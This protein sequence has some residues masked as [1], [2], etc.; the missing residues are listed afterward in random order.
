MSALPVT[1]AA[2]TSLFYTRKRSDVV[3][4]DWTG[5]EVD[6]TRFIGLCKAI[7]RTGAESVQFLKDGTVYLESRK[8]GDYAFISDGAIT[9]EAASVPSRELLATYHLLGLR[10][11]NPRTVRGQSI[12]LTFNTV[13]VLPAE[14]NYRRR[15][16]VFPL[17]D[18]LGERLSRL[19]EFSPVPNIWLTP[20]PWTGVIRTGVPSVTLELGKDIEHQSNHL[21]RITG[22][23]ELE[24]T[25]RIGSRAAKS[26]FA[27][28]ERDAAL[29]GCEMTGH[30]M[31]D[32][33]FLRSQNVFIRIQ[34]H[35]ETRNP[36]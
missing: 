31:G 14:T 30:L 6:L 18:P 9:D 36:T 4:K 23:T 12:R 11:D 17:P 29:N 25:L 2:G 10:R 5:I 33:L 19:G 32:I 35:I 8:N 15:L 21:S 34:T 7:E 27:L 22:T 13:T 3:T 24:G 26:L 28:C 20:R 1:A 16:I